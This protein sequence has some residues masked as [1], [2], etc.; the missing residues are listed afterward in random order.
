M[1]EQV[2]LAFMQFYVDSLGDSALSHVNGKTFL[3]RFSGG[4]EITVR[5]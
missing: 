4:S 3:L 2:D 1:S 5:P